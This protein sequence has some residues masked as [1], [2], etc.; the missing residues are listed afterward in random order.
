MF[1]MCDDCD[2]L[3]ITERVSDHDSGI[4]E[5]SCKECGAYWVEYTDEV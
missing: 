5:Y 4:L 2:S 3:D 1:D